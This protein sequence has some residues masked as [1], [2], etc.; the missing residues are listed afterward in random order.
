[1]ATQASQPNNAT[2]TVRIMF[3]L[4]FALVIGAGSW[5]V[6]PTLLQQLQGM[7][8]AMTNLGLS[9]LVLQIIVTA[10][11]FLIGMMLVMML[12]AAVLPKD[13]RSV[14]EAD[15]AK[16]QAKNFEKRR[17]LSGRSGPRKREKR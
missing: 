4:V 6:A 9:T 16:E 13:K 8:P 1:M 12:M 11:V 15:L 3:Q 5:M 10:I 14:S 2:Q 7:S 17:K